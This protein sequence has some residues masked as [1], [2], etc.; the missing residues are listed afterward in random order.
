V[1]LQESLRDSSDDLAAERVIEKHHQRLA[2]KVIFR[3]IHA[4]QTEIWAFLLSVA[5]A[6]HIRCCDFVQFA[7]EFDT[8]QASE[9]TCTG[10]Q[11]RAAL[12][13][14][15]VNEDK[16]LM[17]YGQLGEP[18]RKF[19]RIDATVV[20]PEAAVGAGN[21]QLAESRVATREY[22]EL[23]IEA[24]L[25]HRS[26]TAI[27][28]LRGPVSGKLS[29][30]SAQQV[31]QGSSRSSLTQRPAQLGDRVHKRIFTQGLRVHCAPKI[32]RQTLRPSI[33][34]GCKNSRTRMP[35]DPRARRFLD[36][37]AAMNPPS[38]LTL[39]VEDRRTALAQLLSLYGPAETV[40]AIGQFEVP[41]PDGALAVRVY[42]PAGAPLGERLAG[43]VYFHGGG[44]VAGSLDTHDSICRSLSNAS[45]CRVLSV[46]YRLAPEHRF[47]AAV[48]DGCAALDWIATHADELSV[49]ARQ[50]GVSGDS[51]GATLA[52]V[53]CHATMAAGRVPLAFQF[54]LC[55]IT[56]F[57]AESDSRRRLAEGYLV[58]RDTL[59][60]DLKHYLPPGVDRADP[61]IS[62]LRAVDVS[63]L[64]PTVVHTAEFDPLC[65]EGRS[66]AERLQQAGVR[67]LYRCH[68]GMIHLFYGLRGLITYAGAAF[69]EMGADIRSLLAAPQ[70][71]ESI[72]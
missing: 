13:R 35:L 49:D 11:Q 32:V 71:E 70:R 10:Q 40:A 44:L 67:T 1:R 7:R 34:A 14:T 68:P 29:R 53:V 22:S 15:K 46:G 57:A 42:T 9:G 6:K 45:G 12:S 3:S 4:V 47:P 37:L 16:L 52:A 56:D 26:N 24:C 66:Y 27:L 20:D 63:R 60:H 58:D 25:F 28:H 19:L 33:I 54:L 43:L 23:R 50:L 2:R 61:R 38:A 31:R 65:D 55:P 48:A 62:P 64:P 18:A 51:A 69:A 17:P 39:S 41:G 5:P 8:D 59:E 36:T 72:R 30:G 21:A